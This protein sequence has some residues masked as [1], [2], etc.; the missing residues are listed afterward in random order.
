MNQKEAITA[1]LAFGDH[2][3]KR[4]LVRVRTYVLSWG[5]D[6]L[7]M[8]ERKTID[9]LLQALDPIGRKYEAKW[10]EY[11]SQLREREQE[12]LAA[13]RAADAKAPPP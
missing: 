12:R 10:E 5:V 8:D 3:A 2:N 6:D 13:Y 9:R 1:G 4:V 7:T 11:V